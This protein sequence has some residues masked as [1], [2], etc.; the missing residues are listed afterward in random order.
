M[1]INNSYKE[2]DRKLI[3]KAKQYYR[4]KNGGFLVCVACNMKPQ[5]FY[6][7][8]GERCIE[9]HHTIPIEELQP[10]SVTLV[11]DLAMVCASCHRIIHSEKPCL[12]IEKARSI[13]K[14]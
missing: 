14:H 11:K 5:E 13:I 10:D 8:S 3:A 1:E 9:A 12:T 7:A 6:G 4:S 2:R